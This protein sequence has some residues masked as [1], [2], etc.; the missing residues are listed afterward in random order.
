MQNT[1]THT[2][3]HTRTHTQNVR[4]KLRLADQFLIQS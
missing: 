1:H 4:E 2:H 3:T